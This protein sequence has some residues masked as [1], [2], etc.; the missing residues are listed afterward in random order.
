MR[1]DIENKG[2]VSCGIE[3]KLYPSPSMKNLIIKNLTQNKKIKLNG[4][5]T[6]TIE[7]NTNVGKKSVNEVDM[8]WGFD[9]FGGV[10]NSIAYSE[11]LNLLVAVGVN[12]TILTSTDGV[13]W[14]FQYFTINNQQIDTIDINCIIYSEALHKFIACGGNNNYWTEYTSSI[15]ISEDGE[16]WTCVGIA[17]QSQAT[18]GILTS[19]TCSDTL[20]VAVGYRG[21]IFTSSDL[22]SWTKETVDVNFYAMYDVTYSTYLEKFVAV[23]YDYTG[24]SSDGHSWIF[25]SLNGSSLTK[26]IY[27]EEKRL[28]VAVGVKIM[29]SVDGVNFVAQEE[30]FTTLPSSVSYFDN[31]GIFIVGH[32]NENI[33]E[34]EFLNST[35]GVNW[36]IARNTNVAHSSKIIFYKQG[37]VFINVGYGVPSIS[38]DGLH[39]K[40]VR[41]CNINTNVTFREIIYI[42]KIKKYMAIG[43]TFAFLSSDRLNWE[44][45]QVND[46]SDTLYCMAY[47]ES[48]GRIVVGS[49]VDNALY[50]SDDGYNW[51]QI[52]FS[53]AYYPFESGVYSERQ[54]KF[55]FITRGMLYISD[56]GYNWTQTDMYLSSGAKITYSNIL[57]IFLIASDVMNYISSDGTNWDFY[58]SQFLHGIDNLIYNEECKIFIVLYENHICTSEN[59]ITWKQIVITNTRL[60][61]VI[62][63][64]SL[65][66]FIACGN[67]NNKGCIATS[68]D[69]NTWTIS[70]LQ[71]NKYLLGIAT[72]DEERALCIVGNEGKIINSQSSIE[73][74][75]IEKLSDDSDMQLSLT[76]GENE[77]LLNN[78]DG[79]VNGT[80]TYRQKYLGV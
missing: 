34:T 79:I 59:G 50:V 46:A 17:L 58:D 30:T 4:T 38:S 10:I 57:N 72:K 41:K 40:N 32:W 49:S 2:D 37:G 9:G 42:K 33:N 56:D 60:Y 75:I 44:Q 78:E 70:D 35:D 55:I 54:R 18:D 39:Y 1:K 61:S 8:T 47:S 19:I 28:F 51:T 77:L 25:N 6:K 65:G 20:V 15:L 27:S 29:T 73:T 45:I 74:S 68:S 63:S 36:E 14:E 53:E 64:K 22:I 80:I 21:N 66:L 26:I 11:E 69:G 67:R 31:L 3:L 71:I 13:N 24:Y 52:T 12:N 7:I 23:G 76:V 48:L 62:Y 5:F 16:N 43:G